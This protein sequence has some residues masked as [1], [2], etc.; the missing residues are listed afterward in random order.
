MTTSYI[1]GAGML[2]AEATLTVG[3]VFTATQVNG[4]DGGI[5]A[6]TLK[7]EITVAGSY[8]VFDLEENTILEEDAATS[9]ALQDNWA[10]TLNVLGEPTLEAT[11]IKTTILAAFALDNQSAIFGMTTT[12]NNTDV[13]DMLGFTGS[14]TWE[15]YT[16]IAPFNARLVGTRRPIG[17]WWPGCP[18]QNPYGHKYPGHWVSDLRHSISPLGHVK[19]LFGNKMRVLSGVSWSHVVKELAITDATDLTGGVVTNLTT[20]SDVPSRSFEE[21]FKDTQLGERDPFSPG[22]PIR[23][24]WDSSGAL[25]GDVYDR[26][27]M[28]GRAS[29]ELPMAVQGYDGLFTVQLGDLIKVP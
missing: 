22:S 16:S 17:V 1:R 25:N 15:A 7:L 18:M 13:R 24:Y 14:E 4:G 19:A 20:S 6:G 27:R 12:W 10:V 5:G 21:F 28:V 23:V 8:D 3:D 11:G 9:A 26:F 29:S 2:T